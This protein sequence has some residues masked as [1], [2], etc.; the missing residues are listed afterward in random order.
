M[1]R[2]INYSICKL[3]KNTVS[4]IGDTVFFYLPVLMGD[5]VPLFWQENGGG[6]CR[7]TTPSAVCLFKT[8][9]PYLDKG[10]DL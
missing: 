2:G 8:S 3:D 10:P 1:V 5:S 6:G 9:F 7:R 4:P